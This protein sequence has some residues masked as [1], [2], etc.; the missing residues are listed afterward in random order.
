MER[1][2]RFSYL[3]GLV[4]APH[5]VSNLALDTSGE[6][7]EP[8]RSGEGRS[9]TDRVNQQFGLMG[10]VVAIELRLTRRRS[11]LYRKNMA[12][13]CRVHPASMPLLRLTFL[14]RF[15]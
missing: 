1:A 11:R 7:V 13:V 5:S 15:L 14:K 10:G 3:R 4:H 6:A 8:M 12:R 9:G 2:G